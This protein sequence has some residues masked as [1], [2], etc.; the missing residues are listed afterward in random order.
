MP[1]KSNGG[2]DSAICAKARGVNMVIR[3]DSFSFPDKLPF[4]RSFLGTTTAFSPAVHYLGFEKLNTC[5]P[6]FGH[7]T[8]WVRLSL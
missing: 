8:R 3:A 1:S 6:Q 5:I 7:R 2:D 4:A